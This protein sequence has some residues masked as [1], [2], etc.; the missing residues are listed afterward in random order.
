MRVLRGET[1]SW[2][3]GERVGGVNDVSQ[4][5]SASYSQHAPKDGVSACSSNAESL[6]KP[7]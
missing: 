5:F 2:I 6:L 7:F 4:S 3:L 1:K